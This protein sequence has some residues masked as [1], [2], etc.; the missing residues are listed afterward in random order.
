VPETL[1]TSEG[2]RIATL[3]QALRLRASVT[4]ERRAYTFLADG[5]EETGHLDYREL[6]ER[7][8]AIAAALRR[9]CAVGDRALLLYPPGL[10]F[11]AAFFG[12]L[13]AGVIAVPA[14]PP[15]SPR[16][17]PRL[18]AI[19][20]D[21]S[22]AVA[23]STSGAAARVA[24]WLAKE[25]SRALSW[26]ATDEIPAERAAE[27]RDPELPDS[28]IAF[29]QYTSGSTSTPKGVM[30]SHGN[31]AHNQRVI[32]AACDHTADSVFVSWLPLYHDLGLIGNLL[33][34]TWVGAPCVLMSP[35]AFLQ[36]PSR[37]LRAISQYGGKNSGGTTS[38]GPNFAYELCLRKVAA[39]ERERL[40]LSSWRVAFNGAEPVRAT[41]MARFSEGF[42][43]A[44]LRREA[45][46]PCYGLAEATLMVSGGHRDE[47]YVARGYDA[48]ALAE[49]RA[50][51][52]AD[53]E[54]ARELVG[55]G[56]VLLDLRVAIVEPEATVALFEGRV[57]EIWVTGDSVAR[58]YWNRPEESERTF[59]ARLA[60][61]PGTW[62]R[63]GDLGFLDRGELFITGRVKDLIIL[64]GRNH[65][66]Q[67]IEL[68]AERAH[69]A[70]RSGSGAAFS[71]EAEGEERL[72]VVYEVD[73]HAEAL[74]E[75][76]EAVRRAVAEEHEAVVHEVVLVPQGGVP[77]TTSGKI[78]RRACRDLYLAAALH[79]LGSS[80]LEAAAEPGPVEGPLR[81]A[82]LAAAAPERMALAERW[83]ARAF[84]RLARVDARRLDPERALTGF[85]LDSLVAV[86]LK[87]AVEDE[88]GVA[89]P[90]AGLLEGMSLRE[91]ALR[92]VDPIVEGA[93]EALEVVAGPAAG[94]HPLSWGQRALWFLH[95]LA[96]ESAA[97][98]IAGAARLAPGTDRAALARALQ[99]LVDRHPGLRATFAA[100]PEGPVQR[101]PERA[102]VALIREDARGWSEAELL[103]RLQGEAFR[104][105]D[106]ERGPVFR[107]ALFEREEGDR[108]ALAVH[109]VAADF[110][111]LAVLVRELGT[112]YG[113]GAG[114]GLPAPA[115][116]YT[117]FA[118]WQE[119]RL[120]GPWGEALWEHWR[121]R[122]AG[123]PPL[124]LAT[125]RP[126]PPAQTFRGAERRLRLGAQRSAGLQALAAAHGS[127]LFVALLA[128][129]Q[130]LLGRHAAQDDFLV[131]SPTTGRSA[132]GLGGRLAGVV[133]YFVNLVALRADLA[134]DPTVPELLA[135]ARGAAL[136]AL[137]HADFPFARLAERLQPE[138]D[139]SRPPL[140]QTVIALQRSPAP[141]LAPLA[142]WAVG[143]AGVRLELGGLALES[144]PLASPAAQFDLTLLAAEL[145]GDLALDLQFN[146]DLFDAVTAERMLAR[147]D[148][149]LG[150]M[151]KDP[152]RRLSELDLLPAAERVQLLAV[153]ATG[154][155]QPDGPPVHRLVEAH[156][157]RWPDRLALADAAESLTYGE[158]NARANRLARRLSALGVGPET[159]VAV[160]LERSAALAVAQLAVLKA[161]AAYAPLDPAYPAE[162]R[163]Y[164]V[165][166]SGALVLIARGTAERAGVQV[167]AVEEGAAGDDPGNPDVAVDGGG[168]GSAAYV[169]YTSGSTG[170]P[171]GVQ[172]SHANLANLIAWVLE[173]YALT[174]EDR[175][176]LVVS[177]SFDVS[178]WEIW[179]TLA[180]GA[181]LHVPDETTRTSPAALVAWLAREEITA[182]FFPTPLVEALLEEP[183]P[184]AARLRVLGCGGDRLRRAPR[185]GTPF[186]LL[187]LYGPAECTV[188]S[189]GGEVPASALPLEGDAPIGVPVAGAAIHLLGPAGEEMPL[190]VPGEIFIGGLGVGRGYLGRPAL[191]AERFV[192]D[193]FSATPGARLY[194]TGDLGRFR[195]DGAVDFL[196]RIDRQVKIRGVRIE[197][198]E[199]E[200]ALAALPEVREAVAE[201][202]AFGAGAPV[203]VAWVVPRQGDPAALDVREL[204][205]ALRRTLPE[206]LIPTVLVPL[207][208][209]PLTP[210]GK[211][212]RRALPDPTG[213]AEGAGAAAGPRTA[214]E[215]RLAGIWGALLGVERIGRGDGFFELGGHS[216]LAARMISRLHATFGVDLPLAELFASPTLAELAVAVER[217]QGAAGPQ[218]EPIPR[219]PR[220]GDL[221]LSF[222]QERLWFLQ[223]LAATPAYNV[224]AFLRLRGPLDGEALRAALTGI[225]R[226]HETLRTTFPE[227]AGE[228]V[229]H[230]RPAGPFPLLE[231]DL[232]GAA[233]PEAAAR[234]RAA[235]EAS[236]PFD[237]QT[238]PL[239]RAILLRLAPTEH[240]L[241]LTLHHAV[242]DGWSTGILLRELTAL[243]GG[244][245]LPAPAV[246][247]ADYAV[248]QR[249]AMTGEA[250]AARLDHW[251]RRLQGAPTALELPSD[252]PRPATQSFRGGLARL[253]LG[254]DLS[255]ALTALGRS[256]GATPFMTLLAAFQAL[257]GRMTNH[258]DL[259]VGAPAANR[260]RPE[261]EGLIG[262]FVN[263]L[264]LRADLGGDPPFSALLDRVR[265]GALEDF[266]H[267]DLPFEKVVDAVAPGRDLSRA[268]LVQVVFALQ[269]ALPALELAPGLRVE[270]E[271]VHNGTSKFDLTLFVEEG[272]AGFEA[273]AEYASDLFDA[274]TAQRLLERLR[275]V[276]AGAAAD[277][278]TP[279]S[280]LPLLTA[281]E[282]LTLVT[283]WS[284]SAP[285]AEPFQVQ[286]RIAEWAAR[287]PER[288]ALVSGT[289]TLTYG[290]M[291]ARANRLAHAL[292]R[293][294]VG[295]ER[296][297]AVCLERSPAAVV[298][299]LAAL[300]VGAAY[301]PLDPVHPPERLA[302]MVADVG[303][304]VV[305]THETV[306]ARVDF[307]A[308]LL[309]LDRET[310]A[311]FPDT[312]PEVRPDPE[313]LA[314]V[315][316]TS[317]S[318]GR[319]KGSG[320]RHAGL[321]NLCALYAA[322]TGMGPE[323]RL[324]QIA[325]PGFDVA[326]GELWPTLVAGASLHFPPDET[327]V[328]P[329]RLLDWLTREGVTICFLP[330][331]L[332]ELVL[333]EPA[334]VALA[335]R[336]FYTGG[337]RL[338][339]RPPAAAAWKLWNIYGPSECTVVSTSWVVEPAEE[340]LPSIGVPVPGARVYLLDRAGELAPAGVPAELWVGGAPV[341]R[342]YLGRPELTAERFRPDPFES[343]GAR[344]YRT[345]D[346]ARFRADGRLDYLGRLDHQVK[347][348]G[349]RV[350]LGEVEAALLALP[351]V[352]EGVVVAREHAPGDKRLVAYVVGREVPPD[353][354]LD[355]S[356]LRDQLRR[357]LPE[358]MVPAAF[359]TLPAL[360]LSA[361]GKV[362]RKA[363]P[364]PDWESAGTADSAPRS[365][366]T[367][368]EELLAGIWAELL[369]LDR[370]GVDDDFFA[371][372]GHSLL[373]ARLTGR[374]RAAF[375]V[376]LPLAEVFAHPTVAGLAREIERA[377]R[378]DDGGG[379][380]PAPPLVPA[381]RVGPLPLSFAQE[382]LWF[383]DQLEAGGPLYNVPVAARLRG[384]LDAGRL[385]AAWRGIARRHEAL[386]TTFPA[387][388]G[389]PVQT[390]AAEPA[391]DLERIE[392]DEAAAF[393]RLDEE[394][395]RPFDLA[396]GPLA[397]ALL[398]RLGADDHLLALTFHHTVADG[399]SMEVLFRELS[400]LYAGDEP[401]PPAVQYPDYAVWQRGWLQGEVL[402]AQLAFW[403][404][405]L[406]PPPAPLDL[407]TDRPRPAAQTFRG[408]AVAVA[409][410]APLV[411]GV[412]ALARRHGATTFMTLLA[413]WSAVLH[414]WS[415]A[416]AIAIGTPVANR[417]PEVE[418]TIGFFVNILPLLTEP[419]AE[420]AFGDLLARVRGRALG[421]YA[422]Q[423]VP[424]ERLVDALAPDRDL[425][426]HPLFQVV[427]ALE[428]GPGA[429]LRLPGLETTPVPVH[430]GTAKF[431]LTL[432]LAGDGDGLAGGLEYNADL[433]DAATAR[434]MAGNL[435]TLLAGAV[436]DAGREI[437]DLPLLGPDEER[438][439]LV[440]WNA[441]AAPFPRG[442]GLHELFAAQAARTPDAT[443]LIWGHERLTYRELDARAGGLARR[444]RR[445]GVGPEILVGIFTRRT[446]DM[447]AAMIAVMRA[448]GAYVPLDPAYPAERVAL[449]LADTA[450]PVLIT[451]GA[452]ADALPP[453][454]G[455]VVLLG[456]ETDP[457]DERDGRNQGDDGLIDPDQ[458]AYTIYTSGSTGLPK[459]ILIR[460][461]SA[462]A[463]IAWA[464]AA[465]P[466]EAM[467]GM[468]ASTSI[469]FDISIFEIFAP[470]ACGGT[471][472]LADDALA[473]AELPAAGEVRLIDTVPSAMAEL[474]RAGA[475]P[476]S[477][478]IVN[479]AGEPLRRDLVS[480][481]YELPHVAAVYNL[482]GPSEDTTF[483]T[484]SNPGRGEAREPTIGRPIANGRLYVLD[485]RLRAVPVGVPGEVWI[486]G[487]G[488]ARGYLN[489]PEL[490]ADRFRPD[491]FAA[492]PGARLYRVGDL[493]RYL[494]DGELEYLGRLDHQVKIRGFRVELGEI[495]A[496]L[497]HHPA[498]REAA[499][500]AREEG[501]TRAL[502]ACVVPAAADEPAAAGD[503]LIDE[504]RRHLA[505]R[506]PA[507]MVPAGFLLL[508]A[509][510]LTPNGKVDRKALA[511]LGPE[512]GRDDRGG[513]DGG[514]Y[515][516]PRNPIEELLAPLWEEVLGVAR[517]G[518]HDDF[519]AL[520][521]HSL[522]GVQL[523][524]R[525]RD[526]FGVKLPVRTLFHASTL[527]DLAERIAEEMAAGVGD[528]LLAELFT[529]GD[530]AAGDGGND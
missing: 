476:P 171:K 55:S 104:P 446:P 348:R 338:T 128:A 165:A 211:I 23:L 361:N 41:T 435:A 346:L 121:D 468:L 100:T 185:P 363:L 262:F 43:A 284:A 379:A 299:C 124:D 239:A 482:Y 410:P 339:R 279:L 125:D 190:G 234:R 18:A 36:N 382:R 249:A 30:V 507:Y 32:A 481:V 452:L 429:R 409:L 222:A 236:R 332:M 54:G 192:P 349:F 484:V 177:P 416:E 455:K 132:P 27:W 445:L 70:L 467:A 356:I 58:G 89:L 237:L 263:L 270:V 517:V 330:T 252:R 306:A 511:R 48:A 135:R 469:C 372:G 453:Y 369:G 186:R 417:R 522:L 500:I 107:A 424:F 376:E 412:R 408:G 436:E 257:L 483:S 39:A 232:T 431:E 460:H 310:F 214:V 143:E 85:G 342:G 427:L 394:A 172:I 240:V 216:L 79:P 64:R 268:P 398:I 13:Y 421:A 108:L 183:W 387:A 156:A 298:A 233:D 419:A 438:Q 490:T 164:M 206:T 353:A 463:M 414:R 516:A 162:R 462:V 231:E 432:A 117:D 441:T 8:R 246:Q 509:L 72:V 82:L 63:T 290:E 296:V 245:E 101:I 17:L 442:R 106:L 444:L 425:S 152:A 33:Q 449:L 314:Y 207:A 113:D 430:T 21:S 400:A 311:G 297:V 9:T 378:E 386:R 151:M 195:P 443:A 264:A 450:A 155:G 466:A 134:G 480:R 401:A 406:T 461:S 92:I 40:D 52:A 328:S 323:D 77:K 273:R 45:L 254:G 454:G 396:R 159:T 486:A 325:A 221:P 193:P 28:A 418:G 153:G 197:L 523:V 26:L 99:A 433:F 278:E 426:R 470:L 38:G 364:A 294:G 168:A 485:R 160:C 203:L 508:P 80:R 87:N 176:A 224:P 354:A 180:A 59:G 83:L 318:T 292:I 67:D 440:D 519:F 271:E 251:R 250:L 498:V 434:R 71:V 53:P 226:R 380:L 374:V 50:E 312:D 110:W 359:V 397:R 103:G 95:R 502:L 375:G 34:A 29:L 120:E 131:G 411:R 96:P 478:T 489:R 19:L 154:P 175:T 227:V 288:P 243:Y 428:D 66:P 259:L 109:H 228:P 448:G 392:L 331:P 347:I 464:L 20:E 496:A 503:G 277:P 69:P 191:T 146:T 320:V 326:V 210:N 322:T 337:D 161:G 173:L 167:L 289:E 276:L 178:V 25:G 334:A 329:P 140:A 504:L 515:V 84:A 269:P 423:D 5:E 283:E 341:G 127:T 78:Q 15:R 65:Y 200:A 377:R 248:W 75:I 208:A 317:G 223:R 11:V 56:R 336:W 360:P 57:G 235:E 260:G 493:A 524:S 301:V 344:L 137:E 287:T 465:Y 300:K 437:A 315:I 182:G 422:H 499:V 201:A 49:H 247:Y 46:Y 497:D 261:V 97:Y 136:D 22:P 256:R 308:P 258:D 189:I 305:L 90:I 491:P 47:V 141:E 60:G 7:A 528:D 494:P 402:D 324:S 473:L 471:V 274:A 370:A 2:S 184:A 477:V 255:A 403:R 293:L 93:T 388:G 139:A 327:I 10:D 451:E 304:A 313:G 122:L 76:A 526:L 307:P 3:T 42:A 405:E 385:A 340:G 123:T 102:D 31:L 272:P 241:G 521:G 316:F 352:R 166:D 118:R 456:E 383:L 358:G 115:L 196:G 111:S 105:F 73:R 404:A 133:G 218:A 174:P 520:G 415:G 399:A 381:H 343:A 457:R 505:A 371:S 91:A 366:R 179:S 158:L 187:N 98:N 68:T 458:T 475:I 204:T 530:G 112:F 291:N 229:Q 335:L 130:A 35:V 148:E 253:P 389:K 495:E 267:D 459:A 474:L 4:P 395:R 319:P 266:A 157:A 88:V 447:V 281:A 198:G 129:W 527:G 188:V 119:K 512:Q 350:E 390:V 373:A 181:S 51:P 169:I 355:P 514:G 145:D 506:L 393:R 487:E 163:A 513:E 303:A 367:L 142:A 14:Y 61:E 295:P 147:L 114:A 488:L 518:V 472:I 529:T 225:A 345:G 219:V 16:M 213:L 309:R 285:A 321:A 407:P 384:P 351:Q 286:Q 150:S 391:L 194:R 12:C 420:R 138:R 265:R 144:I 116:H 94:E 209:L 280:R 74:P 199:V 86:E 37:W 492:A 1:H 244:T 525:V 126:R 81:D 357:T 62:L 215:E 202:R 44:G 149:L 413:A 302:G 365:P 242:T 170:R 212:D 501:A 439:V 217:A 6:D 238:G 220:D 362:D 230:V 333:D 368:T 479:L 24:G 282:R 510:P 205:T 275:V